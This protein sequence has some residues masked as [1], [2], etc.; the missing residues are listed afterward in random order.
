MTVGLT[1][2]EQRRWCSLGAGADLHRVC[3]LEQVSSALQA[4]DCYPLFTATPVPP[5]LVLGIQQVLP[6]CLWPVKKRE[7]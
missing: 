1:G 7:D 6:K 5:Y 2:V 4:L 3:E